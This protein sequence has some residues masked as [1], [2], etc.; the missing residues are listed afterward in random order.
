MRFLIVDTGYPSFLTRCAAWRL[1]CAER[2][3]SGGWPARR[4]RGP[5][6][7]ENG[8]EGFRWHGVGDRVDAHRRWKRLFDFPILRRARKRYL[9]REPMLD[10]LSMFLEC[11]GDRFRFVTL[12]KLLAQFISIC[13][14]LQLVHKDRLAPLENG[15]FSTLWTRKRTA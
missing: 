8:W 12:P 7:R 10:A 2:A 6:G 3:A 13:R 9:D 15:P 14:W 4:P 1:W 5:R 11:L